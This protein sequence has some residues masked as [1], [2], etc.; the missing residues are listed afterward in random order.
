[1]SRLETALKYSEPVNL[2]CHFERSEKSFL[3][4]SRRD[5]KDLSLS[6]TGAT[7]D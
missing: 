2:G 7:E 4:G 6:S 3:S 1:M 5:Q